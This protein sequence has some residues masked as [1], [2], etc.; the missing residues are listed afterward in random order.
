MKVKVLKTASDCSAFTLGHVYSN[1]YIILGEVYMQ[2]GI[3]LNLRPSLA[4]YWK[5]SY[6]GCRCSTKQSR[7]AWAE[8]SRVR[9]KA[10]DT[11][12]FRHGSLRIKAKNRY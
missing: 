1:I 5:F 12:K 6:P 4:V 8:Q 9:T 10:S 3:L 7:V 2:S 11:K